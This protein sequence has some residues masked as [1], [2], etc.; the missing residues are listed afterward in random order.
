MLLF[1]KA[2]VFCNEQ[3]YQSTEKQLICSEN[4]LQKGDTRTSEQCG[5]QSS[6]VMGTPG[7]PGINGLHGKDGA[8]GATGQPGIQGPIGPPGMVI[9]NSII[10]LDVFQHQDHQDLRLNLTSS[11]RRCHFHTSS[12][13]NFKPTTCRAAIL[14]LRFYWHSTFSMSQQTVYIVLHGNWWQ[15]AYLLLYNEL[16]SKYCTTRKNEKDNFRWLLL[17]REITD[18]SGPCVINIP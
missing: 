15:T 2:K 8:P 7:I 11:K 13:Q 1:L 10:P 12:H 17:T 5:C 14:V 3:E 18:T 4:E 16:R 9:I 6:C